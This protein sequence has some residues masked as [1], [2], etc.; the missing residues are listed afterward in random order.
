MHNKV[1]LNNGLF[2]NLLLILINA[3]H[4]ISYMY[5]AVKGN[6]NFTLE[7]VEYAF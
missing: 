2:R 4:L 7:R 5:K 3:E 6:S 1:Y